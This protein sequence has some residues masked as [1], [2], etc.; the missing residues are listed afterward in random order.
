MNDKAGG[1]R[2]DAEDSGL[3]FTYVAMT[4]FASWLVKPGTDAAL[5]VLG[6]VVVAETHRLCFW[7]RSS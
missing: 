6:D 2:T 1:E 5:L 3:G 4:K 7:K